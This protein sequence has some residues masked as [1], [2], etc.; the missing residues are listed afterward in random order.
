MSLKKIPRNE[1]MQKMKMYL[2]FMKK[3]FKRV[4]ELCCQQQRIW[5]LNFCDFCAGIDT[6]LIQFHHRMH[7]HKID[8]FSE[9]ETTSTKM[10]RNLSP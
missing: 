4:F 2:H 10:C 9:A 1:N 3:E 6:R 5:K 8:I 7:V